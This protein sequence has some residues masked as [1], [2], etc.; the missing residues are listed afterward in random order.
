[1]L[2]WGRVSPHQRGQGERSGHPTWPLNWEPADSWLRFGP[3]MGILVGHR[4]HRVIASGH[5]LKFID[6]AQWLGILGHPV[7]SLNWDPVNRGL[8]S[9]QHLSVDPSS[10]S[11]VKPAKTVNNQNKTVL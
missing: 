11:Q 6:W 9:H 10:P 3:Q 7:L 8:L 5:P 2:Q 4:A 1:M